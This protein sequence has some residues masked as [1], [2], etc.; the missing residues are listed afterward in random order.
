LISISIFFSFFVV[1]VYKKLRG[2]AK[3]ENKNL[4]DAPQWP[5]K[6]IARFTPIGKR[7]RKKKR[8]EKKRANETNA[9]IKKSGA[10]VF[11]IVLFF[12]IVF[13]FYFI[14][15]LLLHAH[16]PLVKNKNNDNTHKI[17]KNK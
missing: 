1:S 15:E 16:T 11:S 14:V 8:N 10:P 17:K 9:T 2:R 5:I 7:H 4:Q 13:L 6:N 3:N 12:S